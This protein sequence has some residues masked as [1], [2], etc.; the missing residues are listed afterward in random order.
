MR[1][2]MRGSETLLD[3]IHHLNK[4]ALQTAEAATGYRCGNS[5]PT[6][7]PGGGG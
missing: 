7:G 2:K 6:V 4:F 5:R 3:T 1:T